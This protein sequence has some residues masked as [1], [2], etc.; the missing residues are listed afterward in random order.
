MTPVAARRNGRRPA[1]R[2]RRQAARAGRAC[3]DCRN[4]ATGRLK[5]LVNLPASR[6]NQRTARGSPLRPAVALPA[7][8]PVSHGSADTRL[9]VD[10]LLNRLPER[11]RRAVVLCHLYGFTRTEAAAQLGIPEGTLSARLSRGL[12]KLRGHEAALAV[13]AVPTA[14]VAATARA[15]GVWELTA[16]GLSPV[17][18]GAATRVIHMFLLKKLTA[19]AAVV[20]AG[21][22]TAGVG[23]GLAAKPAAV[24]ADPPPK[25]GGLPADW[26]QSVELAGPSGLK[27]KLTARVEK[28]WVVA[29]YDVPAGFKVWE[30]VLARATDPT[31]PMVTADAAT[32]GV[33]VEYGR[34]S[35]RDNG[36]RLRVV[37][38]RKPADWAGPAVKPGESVRRQGWS[39][40]MYLSPSNRWMWVLCGP[41]GANQEA[42]QSARADICLRLG[43]KDAVGDGS[44]G[45][46]RLT[47][48]IGGVYQ[49]EL[50]D[51][52]CSDD[53]EV[54]TAN[55]ALQPVPPSPVKPAVPPPPPAAKLTPPAVN[56]D[57]M[58]PADRKAFEETVPVALT[59]T[60]RDGDGKPIPNAE[61]H[62]NG[63]I[64]NDTNLSYGY[65]GHARTDAAGRYTLWFRTWPDSTVVVYGLI[66]EADGFVRHKPDLSV[67]DEV[68]V[69]PEQPGRWDFVLARGELLAGTVP[70]AVGREVVPLLVR[71]PSFNETVLLA[72]GKFRLWVP[73]G[74]YTLTAVLGMK[75]VTRP[76]L[77]DDP[78]PKVAEGAV[79]TQSAVLRDVPSGS[80]DLVVK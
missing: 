2:Q 14:M 7:D 57:K 59:G 79:I 50:G 12:A 13:A 51:Y 44:K 37:R 63:S 45:T 47:V 34:Y 53:G 35:I 3:A 15:V 52:T 17:A 8:I 71:G 69:R 80:G 74:R 48:V 4:P 32:A 21:L 27:A 19:A 20:V 66:A 6:H 73:N 18:S 70:A 5:L 28:G 40:G 49:A 43:D 36:Y 78:D 64:G 1:S 60:V 54:L 26:K 75:G 29:R 55:Y 65:E 76:G 68:V 67:F 38:E 9:D 46:G 33:A 25:A 24:A 31:P 16:A 41:F 77:A 61:V 10:D 72:D 23:V 58:A 56:L 39:G 22:T 42:D 11:D 62:K 30:V